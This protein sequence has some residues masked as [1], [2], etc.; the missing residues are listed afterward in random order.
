M[1]LVDLS[2]LVASSEV[3][4][5]SRAAQSLGRNASTISRR[6]GRLEDELGLALFERRNS[7]VR[8]TSGGKAVLVHVRRALAEIDAIKAAGLQSGIANIGE[9]HLGVRM[10][11]IGEPISGLLV[12]WRESHPDVLIKIAELPD[13]D[14]AAALEERRLNVALIPS[15]TLW[16]HAVSLPIY[17]EGIL[18]ALP[19]SHR[20]A[21]HATLSW[22]SL[23][24]EIVLVQ[25]WD[26]SKRS[27]RDACR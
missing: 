18:A 15:F 13:H 14:I 16:P 17:R 10:P 11:P 3:G 27:V 6:I 26:E 9:L 25:G 8:L 12:K 22:S 2:Y 5:F 20:L 21:R 7:G 23:R 24:D 4:N 19:A 1:E